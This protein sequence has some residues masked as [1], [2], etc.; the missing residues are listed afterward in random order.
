MPWKHTKL[1]L[2]QVTFFAPKNASF[3]PA[4]LSLSLGVR[5]VI[6]AAAFSHKLDR[7]SVKHETYSRLKPVQPSSDRESPVK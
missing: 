6:L 3:I 7:A 2:F 5:L 4:C 1:C